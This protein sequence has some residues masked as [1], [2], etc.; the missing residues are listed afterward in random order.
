MNCDMRPKEATFNIFFSSFRLSAFF[1]H[2]FLSSNLLS[3]FLDLL[4]FHQF[5]LLFKLTRM[6]CNATVVNKNSRNI[7][8]NQGK[9]WKEIFDDLFECYALSLILV[10]A[11]LSRRRRKRR[12][13]QISI[14][15]LNILRLKGLFEEIFVEDG[16]IQFW[17][18][19]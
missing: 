19:F 7:F 14:S 18:T 1:M 13:E 2:L 10:Y 12:K 5:L 11:G 16:I 3:K 15:I 17:A 6:Q 8:E 4:L 9:F